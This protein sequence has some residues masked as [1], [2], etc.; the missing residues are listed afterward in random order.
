MFLCDKRS[1]ISVKVED[2]LCCAGA[3][4]IGMDKSI[5]KRSHMVKKRARE[6]HKEA[7]TIQYNNFIDL[8]RKGFSDPIYN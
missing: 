6:L 2:G 4:A 7:N 1:V 8:P 3:L 5:A